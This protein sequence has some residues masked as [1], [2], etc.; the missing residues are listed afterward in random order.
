MDM[1]DHSKKRSESIEK[2]ESIEF[3]H[4]NLTLIN[5]RP[6]E[7]ELVEE[8][9]IKYTCD[10]LSHRVLSNV[11]RGSFLWEWVHKRLREGRLYMLQPQEKQKCGQWKVYKG[12]RDLTRKIDHNFFR[13]VNVKD[14]SSLRE[15]IR[16]STR[17]YAELH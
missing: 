12:V 4:P 11:K 13:H 3:S 10:P 15:I 14:K 7:S 8:S 2:T 17:G 6:D 16:D 9:K 1:N 5:C